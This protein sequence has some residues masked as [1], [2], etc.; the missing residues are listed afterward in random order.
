MKFS[1]Q[2]AYNSVSDWRLYYV[3]YN[4][5]KKVISRLRKL[6]QEEWLLL[7][8]SGTN[9]EGN[10]DQ[11]EVGSSSDEDDD[12][13][14]AYDDEGRR[15]RRTP[16]QD[17]EE[18]E[19]EDEE[20]EKEK[21]QGGERKKLLGKD[22]DKGE[23]RVKVSKDVKEFNYETISSDPTIPEEV[24]AGSLVEGSDMLQRTESTKK[25]SINAVLRKE[26]RKTASSSVLASLEA[27]G[28]VHQVGD[29]E[30]GSQSL[31]MTKGALPSTKM[32]HL[33]SHHASTEF[34]GGQEAEDLKEL[35]WQSRSKI[36]RCRHEFDRV[37]KSF[38]EKLRVEISKVE[39]FYVHM[40][41]ELERITR[42]LSKD[43]VRVLAPPSKSDRADVSHQEEL[44]L[45][46]RALRKRYVEHYLELVELQNFAELNNTAVEKILKKHDKNTG[47]VTRQEFLNAPEYRN[48]EFPR[49]S[50]LRALRTEAE[51]DFASMF[52]N[53]D[54][55]KAT[56]EL[57][58]S[59]HEIVVW[60]R[61]TIWRDM[62][63]SERRVRGFHGQKT[64]AGQK[65]AFTLAV[66]WTALSFSLF[67]GILVYIIGPTLLGYLQ[68]TS[69]TKRGTAPLEFSD[70]TEGAAQR[71]LALLTFVIFMWATEAVPLYIT[72][73][74]VPPLTVMLRVFLEDETGLPLV[75]SAASSKAL[76]SMSS[77][78]VLLIIGGYTISA[79]L[80]KYALD[81]MF[82]SFVLSWVRDPSQMLLAIMLLAVFLAMWVSNVATPVLLN[83]IVLTILRGMP[84]NALP[85]V[86][87]VLMGVAL[88]SNIGGMGSPIASPQ[89]AVA[90]AQLKNLHQI[91]FL[92]W[93]A[94]AL[95]VALFLVL[96]SHAILVLVYKPQKYPLPIIPKHSFDFGLTHV[97]ILLTLF[98]TLFLW[99]YKPAM[100]IIGSEGMIAILPVVVYFG[101]GILTK[102]DFN[103]LPWNVIYLVSGGICMG[104]AVSSS[105][106]LNM[107]ASALHRMLAGATLWQV[108]VVFCGFIYIVSSMISHTVS[109]II[110]LPV[111]AELGASLGHPRLL[112]MGGAL[113]CSGAMA[114]PVSSFPN[115]AAVSVESELGKP[116]LKASDIIL[117][118]I[119]LTL[120]SA[121]VT[122]TAGYLLMY[123]MGF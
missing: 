60:E 1:K 15:R 4:S 2:L 54:L 8:K 48:L 92:E 99:C 27:E 113:A 103:N 24:A 59:L 65:G 19:N 69:S 7:N 85:L 106:L 63:L 88:A 37:E 91:S 90:L 18:Q 51:S 75:A 5:L 50:K 13:D 79:A 72:S 109:A 119:P 52:W 102:E 62:L 100:V 117:L 56:Q 73:L 107:I 101:L 122:C 93:I 114:L 42:E 26:L 61:N 97:I 41:H 66:K 25:A 45:L 83:S 35:D 94:A 32:E 115:M 46:R 43:S 76:S 20:K 22:K 111:V 120:I 36:I 44:V 17:G 21:E 6:K 89:N 53:N 80:S 116:Y 64:T 82:S 40:E 112:V 14:A 68:G 31:N 28:S 47:K 58:E 67:L 123:S 39:R 70:E 34:G 84:A 118:G 77:S 86:K 105:K 3:Q 12:D 110:V 121:V 55:E 98:S 74:M 104:A 81:R 95:P 9:L 108:Y 33:P 71:C 23:K 16:S 87:C 30:D 10:E 96:V 29:A 78:V 11:G 49:A 57:A 38:F